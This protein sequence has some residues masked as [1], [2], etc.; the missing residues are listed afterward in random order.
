MS[1]YYP[2]S[3]TLSEYHEVTL[4]NYVLDS[5]HEDLYLFS[6][7]TKVP[8]QSLPRDLLKTSFTMGFSTKGQF[9]KHLTCFSQ[10]PLHNINLIMFEKEERKINMLL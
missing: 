9:T 2:F 1:K 10:S 7:Q 3:K 4:C 8:L 6:F 5:G